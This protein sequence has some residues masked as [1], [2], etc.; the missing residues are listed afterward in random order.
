[1]IERPTTP[2]RWVTALLGLVCVGFLG[3]WIYA[4]VFASKEGVYFVTDSTWRSAAEQRCAAAAD[5]R[6]ALATDVGGRITDPTPEQLT[7][8]ADVV[9]RATDTIE[10]MIADITDIPVEGERNRL[11]V[12]QW[13]G[14]YQT[15]IADRRSF[16]ATLRDGQNEPFSETEVGGSPVGSVLI[17]FATGNDVE[18]CL[19]PSDLAQS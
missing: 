5:D 15:L 1:V 3:M 11:R 6:A 2:R 9:D 16:T 17:D 8:R 4:F 18:A 12:E 13:A 14:F 7:Q 10:A 19:P